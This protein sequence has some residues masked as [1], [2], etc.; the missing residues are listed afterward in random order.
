M[1]D[2]WFHPHGSLRAGGWD[3]VV[4]TGMPGWHHAGLRVADAAPG[5][6]L[7][8]P[9][10]AVER[11]VIPLAGTFT[12]EHRLSGQVMRTQLHGRRSVFEGPTDVLYLPT[13]T[14]AVISGGGR[15]AIASAPTDVVHPSRHIGALE[16]PVELRG[17]GSASRQVHDLG[18]PAVLDAARLIVCEVITPSG[19]WSSYPPHRHD[20]HIAGQQS[21]LEEIY[22]FASA[23][24]GGAA[25]V[26]PRAPFGM[27]AAYGSPAGEIE[28]STI[29]RDGDVALVPHGYHGPAVAAPGYDLYYLNV[30]AGPDVERQWLIADDPAHSWVRDEWPKTP[31]DTRLPYGARQ[32]GAST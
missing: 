8:L 26:D 1:T 25:S 6:P 23:R 32:G 12:V 2:T 13:G 21:R 31:V 24:A 22:Y 28:I 18:T 4:D 20:E 11:L 19:N 16:V 10:A 9:S 14:A 3:V 15:V 29:V 5:R 7:T 17:A 27:F 30:M